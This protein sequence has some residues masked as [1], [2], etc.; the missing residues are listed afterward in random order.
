M[1]TVLSAL[2]DPA[3]PVF[4]FGSTPPKDGTT[5]EKAKEAY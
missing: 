3:R 1:S 4:L 2:L 5:V